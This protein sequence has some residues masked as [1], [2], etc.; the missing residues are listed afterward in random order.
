MSSQATSG[1]PGPV[2]LDLPQDVLLSQT[3]EERITL[4]HPYEGPARPAG[5]PDLVKE[6]AELLLNA[7]SPLMIVGK[8]VPLVRALLGATRAG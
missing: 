6:A 7:E 2:F 3:D 1:R 4:P 5:D 8:G